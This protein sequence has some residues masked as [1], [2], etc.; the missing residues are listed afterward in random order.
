MSNVPD[1]KKESP[2]IV[3]N[4]DSDLEKTAGNIDSYD[5]ILSANASHRTYLDIEP[6]ISVRTSFN[7]SDYYRFREDERTGS[8]G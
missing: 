4:D 7:K 1:K 6:N 5:G 8:S 2:Y 3:W